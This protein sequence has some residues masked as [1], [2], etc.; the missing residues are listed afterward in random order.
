MKMLAICAGLRL[1]ENEK[2]YSDGEVQAFCKV[3]SMNWKRV[4]SKISI[5]LFS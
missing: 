4:T 5:F 2:T 3:E 1:F